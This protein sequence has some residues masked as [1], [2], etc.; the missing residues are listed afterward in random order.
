MLARRKMPVERSDADAGLA[1]NLLQRGIDAMRGKGRRRDLDQPV[2]IALRIG[3]QFFCRCGVG[4]VF[5]CRGRLR[6][7]FFLHSRNMGLEPMRVSPHVINGGASVLVEH[8]YHIIRGPGMSRVESLQA[9]ESV[10]SPLVGEM[11]GRPEG[12]AVPPAYQPIAVTLSDR[13]P[14]RREPAGK[15]RIPSRPP[16][17][18]RASPPRGGR[19]AFISAFAF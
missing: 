14:F 12:G 1:G 10:I 18:C 19:S 17:P 3:A 6:S 9:D 4:F 5:N 2:A 11:A 13:F 7:Q 16:L 8:P 15:V